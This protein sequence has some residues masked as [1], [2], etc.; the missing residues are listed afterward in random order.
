[1]R[2]IADGEEYRGPSTID[3]PAILPEIAA[4]VQAIGYGS[5]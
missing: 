5:N 1:M 2:K 4:T 3:A